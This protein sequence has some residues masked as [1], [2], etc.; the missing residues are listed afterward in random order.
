MIGDI[1]ELDGTPWAFCTRSILKSALTRLNAAGGVTLVSAC[2]HEFQFPDSTAA[3]GEADTLGG[4][5]RR[6]HF[7]EALFAALEQGGLTTG[8]FMKEYGPEQYEATIAGHGERSPERENQRNGYRPR[9]WD[10]RAGTMRITLSSTTITGIRV[11]GSNGGRVRARL[12]YNQASIAAATTRYR[13]ALAMVTR[14]RKLANGSRI[15][16]ATT[17]S[18]SPMIGTQLASRLHRP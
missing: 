12:R 2:E 7:G 4:F 14:I 10:T 3:P 18:G 15:T 1:Q 17:V 11:G 9:L 13:P 8:T 6:R 5:S 16:P